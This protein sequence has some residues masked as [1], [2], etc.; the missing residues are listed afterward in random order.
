MNLPGVYANKIDKI[1]KNND[2]YYREDKSNIVKRDVRELRRYFDRSGYAEKLVV[3]LYYSDNK[4]SIE[5]L[6][7]CKGDC[8]INIDNKKIYFDDVSNFEVQ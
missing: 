4:S 7:L 5:R 8:F 1:I 2:D 3:K 6:I